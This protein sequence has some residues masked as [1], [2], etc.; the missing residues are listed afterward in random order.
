MV[1]QKRMKH[2]KKKECKIEKRKSS[3]RQAALQKEPQRPLVGSITTAQNTKKPK[4]F[5]NPDTFFPSPFFHRL[6][7]KSYKT[8]WTSSAAGALRFSSYLPRWSWA[9]RQVLPWW[10]VCDVTTGQRAAFALGPLGP[11]A[12]FI[13]RAGVLSKS[14]A[15]VSVISTLL[16]LF[17]HVFTFFLRHFTLL[18]I[19]YWTSLVWFL[20]ICG[21]LGNHG[22]ECSMRLLV[23]EVAQLFKRHFFPLHAFVVTV[24]Q[25][26][27]FSVCCITC[28]ILGSCKMKMAASWGMQRNKG[29]KPSLRGDRCRKK[30][31]TLQITPVIPSTQG[32]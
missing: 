12:A 24:T 15:A 25:K 18:H 7:Q 14:L 19:N 8:P 3:R 31:L 29:T 20:C 9:L 22:D 23:K 26:P 28:C 11:E 21:L 27:T 6:T 30:T 13:H 5:Q 16:Y 10:D 32:I 2:W 4:N 1:L 17:L